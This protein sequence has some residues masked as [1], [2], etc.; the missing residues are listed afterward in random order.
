MC[1]AFLAAVS[2]K[3]RICLVAAACDDPV[4]NAAAQQFSVSVL[5]SDTGLEYVDDTT[6]DTYF[7]V[8]EFEGLEYDVLCRTAHRF[9]SVDASRVSV[10]CSKMKE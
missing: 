7:V 6:Y 3:K 4:I 2:S 1:I 9:V 10:A 8:K 5:K